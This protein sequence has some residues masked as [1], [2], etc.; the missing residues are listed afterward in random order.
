MRVYVGYDTKEDIAYQ[1]CEHSIKRRNRQIEVIPLKQKRRKKQTPP[2][3]MSVPRRL[4]AIASPRSPA[5]IRNVPEARNSALPHPRAARPP[6]MT[7]IQGKTIE[8]FKFPGNIHPPA[9]LS[10][11]AA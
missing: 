9:S 10:G 7:P 1:V 6:R 11:A 3:R 5:V 2:M 8:P 4:R